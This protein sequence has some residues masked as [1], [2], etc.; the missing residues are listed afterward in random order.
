MVKA[1]LIWVMDKE[2]YHIR[3]SESRCPIFLWIT[4]TET[5][6]HGSQQT[7]TIA[8]CIILSETII[9]KIG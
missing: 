9:Y 6:K 8:S 2:R 4:V 7:N 1:I 3:S 5:N